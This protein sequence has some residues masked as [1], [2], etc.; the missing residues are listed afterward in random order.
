MIE[1][2]WQNVITH[3]SIDALLSI[4][5]CGRH[6]RKLSSHQASCCLQIGAI[7]DSYGGQDPFLGD[8]YMAK[9]RYMQMQADSSSSAVL[10]QYLLAMAAFRSADSTAQQN[11]DATLLLQV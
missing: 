1:S 10:Q 7:V 6:C 11:T 5:S 2:G 4:D 8:G 9:G 3:G